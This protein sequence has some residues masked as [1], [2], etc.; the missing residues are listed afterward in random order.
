MTSRTRSFFVATIW[1]ASLLVALAVLRLP[2]LERTLWN[3]DEAVTVTMAQQIREGA[4]LYRDTVDHRGP[5]VP[6]LKAAIF[7]VA[8][9]WNSRAV[10][11][12]LALG[13][14]IVAFRLRSIGRHLGNPLAGSCSAV[15]FVLLSSLL[16]GPA[17]SLA[18]HTEWFVIFFSALGFWLLAR[19]HQRATFLAGIPIGLAFVASFLSKQPGIL[20]LG[21]A[22]VW[23]AILATRESALRQPLVRLWL[24]IATTFGFV[25]VA[26]FVYFAQHDALHDF[27]YYSW[28]YNTAL[29]VPEIPLL[30]RWLALSVPFSL[31]VAHAPALFIASLLSLLFLLFRASRD[32]ARSDS[33]TPAFALLLLGW[34]AS[35]LIA[36]AL[37]GRDFAHYSIQ[38]LPGLSLAAG[39]LV[40]R[41]IQILRT[42]PQRPSLRLLATAA[43]ALLVLV[44]AFDLNRRRSTLDPKDDPQHA[45]LGLLLQRHSSPTERLFVWGY[46]PEAHLFSQRLPATRF[47]YANFLSGLI[48]WTNL[49]YNLDTRYAVVPGAWSAFW[50]DYHAQ[51]PALILEAVTRGY[52][53]YPLLAQ[54]ALRDELIA[55]Y[56]EIDR[57][58]AEPLEMRL[59]RR[60]APPPVFASENHPVDAEITLQPAAVTAAPDLVAVTVRAS[61]PASSLTLR[62]AG[63]P[64]RHLPLPRE[65]PL[66]ATFILRLSEVS[67]PNA[68]II[69]AVADLTDRIV[70]SPP[71]D[72]SPRLPRDLVIAPSTPAL[73]F[74][75]ELLASAAPPN[76]TWHSVPLEQSL[77]WS[78]EHAF[79]LN[80]P[81][82]DS[83]NTFAFEWQ[84]PGLRPDAP[85]SSRPLP[86]VF[87][88][89]SENPNTSLALSS[90]SLSRDR[91]HLVA[92][93][94]AGP[95]RILIQWRP[96]NHPPSPDSRVWIGALRVYADGP[97]FLVRDQSIPPL[98]ALA[99]ADSPWM[100]TPGS[101]WST[102]PHARVVYPR[103]PHLESFV[104][105]F[106]LV[107][108]DLPAPSENID[109][110]AGIMLEA[111]FLHRDGRSENLLSHALQ[112]HTN[113][114]HLERQSAR[115]ALPHGADGQIEL[116]LNSIPAD[117]PRPAAIYLH[118]PRAQGP[119]PDLV[120]SPDGIIVPTE[121]TTAS[122]EPIRTQV[123]GRWIAHAPGFLVYP[124]PGDLHAVEFGFG[125]EEAAYR[126]DDGSPRSNGIHVFVEFRD[127]SE[128]PIE[129]FARTLD[130]FNNP[131]DRGPQKARIVTP[132]RPGRLVF[133][134]HPGPHN[135]TGYDWSYWTD[136]IGEIATPSTP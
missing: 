31:G 122:G 26:V 63:V 20:D 81:R 73:A 115:V 89:S 102:R 84:P 33:A 27:L 2:F 29:Y 32:L 11:V 82:L 22:F 104:V 51:P 15:A 70:Q 135:D 16:V 35:G 25:V 58:V 37:S 96:E 66:E 97:R 44:T 61:F 93:L 132:G 85:A 113:P 6:Y 36:T 72:L 111:N 109:E 116:K 105:D 43:L 10:H 124:C 127:D 83:A 117:H 79:S 8:G 99:P 87:F 53:K 57:S 42:R 49:D 56:A 91:L 108:T 45:Q 50:S 5:L 7:S 136:F 86:A 110:S 101:A 133:Y 119:G 12:V 88:S 114:S 129:L 71:F 28:R 69:D 134:L 64:L 78:T 77:G 106:G 34:T 68:T 13:L 125:L 38:L 3:L 76:A 75:N 17:E 107:D 30:T 112:P 98:L 65:H 52:V 126:N 21:V 118:P 14:G 74:G 18:A 60:L 41:C 103:P 24:G 130:P 80:Y 54:P 9:D 67:S 55:H 59:Y 19:S 40:A 131:A 46:F 120:I 121:S 94:P 128:Q 92:K 123:N 23:S 47:I 62:R 1:L 90:E 100:A 4:V 95:G 48:P 39:W